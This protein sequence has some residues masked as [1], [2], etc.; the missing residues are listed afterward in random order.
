MKKQIM[1]R[2][3]LIALAASLIVFLAAIGVVYF[4]SDSNIKNNIMSDTKVYA[5]IL[6][7]GDPVAIVA[8]LADFDD[9]RGTRVYPDGDGLF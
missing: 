5:D 8:G 3:V 2:S 7:S 6:E 1:L 9:M 4:V